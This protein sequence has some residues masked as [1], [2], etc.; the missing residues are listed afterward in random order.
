VYAQLVS[1]IADSA[2]D[3][4][5]AFATHTGDLVQN[6]VDPNQDD[7]RAR[8]EY[9]RAS[10]AQAILD[11]AGVPNSV[12]P[13]NHDNKRGVSN[14]LFN[15]YFPP[16]RYETAPTYGGSIAPDDNSA[17]FSTFEQ[18]GARFLMLS[19]PYAYGDE[20][21]EWAS[22]VVTEHPDCNV[23]IS[24][25]EHVT[26]KT[27][28][29]D[30]HRSANSRWVSNGQKLWD[31]V[32]APNRNVVVVLSGHF[33]GIGQIVT[34]NAGGIEGHDVVELLADYQEF[35]THTGERATGFQRL[36][37]IDLA[38]ST[39]AVDTFSVRLDAN[40][41]FDYDYQQFRPDSG[42]SN[43]LSNE[44]P[45][46]IVEAGVQNRYT[47]EDDEFEASVGFQFEKRVDTSAITVKPAAEAPLA[48][49][50]SDWHWVRDPNA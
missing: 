27:D 14:D 28:V 39:V 36:L 24:T 48:R 23:V 47:A 43:S 21:I 9:E 42:Q 1:W 12:L 10:A 22:R 13:G 18:G 25:H 26:P 38:S 44:R 3:R 6:W 33:H 45:W 31:R 40:A 30:A 32:I 15:E 4:K 20:Q 50:S 2:D 19:L 8:R 7:A 49:S 29:E 41:S 37:Q 46:R 17:N 16:S 5:I 11:D 35:R 34:E